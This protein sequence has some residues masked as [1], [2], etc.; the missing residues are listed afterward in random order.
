MVEVITKRQS[1]TGWSGVTRAA[2]YQLQRWPLH[3]QASLNTLIIV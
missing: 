3:V 1:T 2:A